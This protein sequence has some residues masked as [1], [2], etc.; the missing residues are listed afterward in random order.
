[1]GEKKA[2]FSGKYHRTIGHIILFIQDEQ[3]QLVVVIVP[4]FIGICEIFVFVEAIQQ[5]NKIIIFGNI[6]L[7]YIPATQSWK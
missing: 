3:C 4:V 7:G 6:D 2:L 5:R 1:M